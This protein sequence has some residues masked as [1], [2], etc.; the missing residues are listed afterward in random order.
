MIHTLDLHFQV[1]GT[2]A[3][4]VIETSEGPVL[5][6]TGPHSVFGNLTDGLQ[7]LGYRVGDVKHVLLSHIHF[8]HAGAAWALAAEG[9]KVYVH[10]VGRPHLLDPTRLYES[11]RRIYQGQMEV[12]WGRMEGIPDQQLLAVDD[13]ERLAIGDTT[14][15]AWHTPGH[16][17]HHIAWQLNTEVFTGD[18]GGCR[19]QGGP[20][21]PPC[22]PP[23]I[24]LEHWFASIARLRKLAPSRLYLTHFGPV[25]DV[26]PHLDVLERMLRDWAN[27]MK[28]EWEAGNAPEEI[29]PRFQAYVSGQLRKAGASDA[30]LLQYEAANPS[31]MSVAGL[32]RYWK[33]QHRSEK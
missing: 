22:P 1:P 26:G 4:F 23:D 28:P 5:I 13:G 6:E 12:L 31:W 15:T 14:F 9:A 19:I 16:A 33:Q 7:R 11:A 27:W 8:D 30:M 17:K 20:V 2:I 25:S 32:L 10:P 3:S 24:H 21:V 29:V 18:V